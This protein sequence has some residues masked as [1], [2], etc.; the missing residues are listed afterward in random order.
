MFSKKKTLSKLVRTQSN[1]TRRRRM[2][3]NNK[4]QILWRHRSYIFWSEV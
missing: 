1:A 3:S 2:L 4:K